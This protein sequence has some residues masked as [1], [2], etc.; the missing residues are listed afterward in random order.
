M[1]KL[2]ID[3][4]I[5]IDHLRGYKP[6]TEYLLKKKSSMLFISAMTVAELYAGMGN[7]H[8]ETAVDKILNLFQIMPID[9]DIS[10]AGGHLCKKHKKS[11]GT[12]LADALIAA[13]AL[14]HEAI[15]VTLNTKHF[16]MVKTIKP[17]HK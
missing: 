11:H 17:Y 7:Q 5:I 14:H 1:D 9:H 10:I 15:L 6:A 13:T 3:T 16:P 12:G 4:D 2:L 8:E